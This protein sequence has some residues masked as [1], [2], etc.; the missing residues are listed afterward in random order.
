VAPT[1]SFNWELR[2]GHAAAARDGI[3]LHHTDFKTGEE[4]IG[5][6]QSFQTSARFGCRRGQMVQMKL[7]DMSHEWSVKMLCRKEL[8]S[9]RPGEGC[10]VALSFFWERGKQVHKDQENRGGEP[11]GYVLKCRTFGLC[12]SRITRYLVR[13]KWK[14]FF[15]ILIG[16]IGKS[17][18]GFK[19]GRRLETV[20]EQRS[21]R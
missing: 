19:I 13:A 12:A 9:A 8:W 5:L 18:E 15:V 4:T 11:T 20:F 14:G 16:G 7:F 2:R 3:D 17:I 21:R 6:L 1:A 10:L